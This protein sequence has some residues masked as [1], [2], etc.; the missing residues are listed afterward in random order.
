M[1]F[2]HLAFSIFLISFVFFSCKEKSDSLPVGVNSL[3]TGLA[4]PVSLNPDTTE[5][6][7]ADY[8][9]EIE[10]LDS[11]QRPENL[12]VSGSL[13][14]GSLKLIPEE[15]LLP[16]S[17]LSFFS[18]GMKYDILLKKS[19]KV[20]FDF[21]FNDPDQK[22]QQ[23][24]ILG[25]INAW[26]PANTTVEYKDGAWTSSMYLTPGTYGYQLI[27]DGIQGLDPQNPEKMENGIGG[28]N[29]PLIIEGPA[30]SDLPQLYTSGTGS[31]LTIASEGNS[32]GVYVFWENSM[33]YQSTESG[34][35]WTI[36][37]PEAAKKMQRSFIRAFA[38]NEQGIGSDLFIPLQ[39]GNIITDAGNLTRDDH[40]S[41]IMYFLM[42]DRFVNGDTGNDKPTDDPQIHPRANFH[43]GDIQGIIQKLE[44]GY[45]DSLGMNTIWLSPIPRNPDGAYG[46]WD[47]GGVKSKFSSYHGY[48][49]TGLSAVD[50]R[51]GNLAELKKLITL[52]HNKDIN[53]ILD[54]VAHHV[55]EEHILYQE[56]K[57]SGWFTDLHLPD[58]TLNTERWDEHRLT[59][60]FDV[61]LP[62]FRFDRDDVCDMLSDTAMFWLYETGIDGFRHDATKHIDLKFWRALTKKVKAYKRESG[63]PVYQVGETY[64]TPEL[65]ASYIQSGMLDAQ[66]DFNL[67][68]AFLQ[69]V[70]IPD[71]G[72]KEV[73]NRLE[74]S[75]AYYGVN[76]LMGNMSG[77]QDK[78]RLMA[79][80]TGDVSLSEDGKLAGWTRAV[81]KTTPEGFKKLE[82][83]HVLNL[84]V[85]GVPCIYYGD[86][87]GLT[88]G[89][90]PD[91]RRMMRF[92]SL[93]NEADQLRKNVG[94]LAMFRRSNMALM[95][96]NMR[97]LDTPDQVL[98]FCRKYFD[99]E[100]IVLVNSSDK[101]QSIEVRI[102][103]YISREKFKDLSGKEIQIRDKKLK[104]ILAPHSYLIAHP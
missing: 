104:L 9:D 75:F 21:R 24:Q 32:T 42:V 37:I 65:I 23:V 34:N 11:F 5:L 76:H 79:L 6:L 44:S 38:Y 45:F 69:S 46:W 51:F 19:A 40:H 102:P 52:A 48:W 3:V 99:N 95:Y 64:G 71:K 93:H 43:G 83:M 1:R 94:N 97:F 101:E 63:R 14:E 82:L 86:E 88:G 89:N 80:A 29:S 33:I 22:H 26:N 28:Y 96:G 92:D 66:F 91:N 87:I 77:N 18:N 35:Q 30:S 74:Q 72:F 25:D 58:G 16:L 81:E 36:F 73:R 20:K 55:H 12:I 84:S 90:D 100:V 78:T 4:S 61:F 7:L 85:P 15:G 49:P 60:W 2:I 70:C 39:F 31:E 17:I 59:T 103:D 27:I 13:T 50:P 67:Y 47:K 57:D 62:T 54:F 41:Q 98:G 10:K 68:D 56:K 8:F 53:V